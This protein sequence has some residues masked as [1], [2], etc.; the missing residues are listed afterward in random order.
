MLQA[1][2]SLKIRSKLTQ[3]NQIFHREISPVSQSGIQAGSCMPFGE[4][5]TVTIRILRVLRINI[6]FLKIEISK[7]IRSRQGSA[8]M[9]GLRAMHGGHDPFADLIRHFGE[10]KVLHT[11]SSVFL[12]NQGPALR[13]A[14]P[15][16]VLPTVYSIC[17]LFV[18]SKHSPHAFCNNACPA[19]PAGRAG[20]GD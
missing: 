6:H 19:V 11:Y 20:C 15:A 18:H 1:G 16:P 17:P 9:A 10:F 3:R 4:H 7:N 2:M 8:R 5:K 13:P 12:L 14:V